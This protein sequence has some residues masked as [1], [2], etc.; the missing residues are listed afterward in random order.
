MVRNIDWK[1]SS[2]QVCERLHELGFEG[3]YDYMHL[4]VFRSGRNNQGFFFVN[5]K[6][7]EVAESFRVQL[8]GKSFGNT[9][10]LCSIEAAKWQGL[11]ELRAGISGKS[12]PKTSP[13][14][15]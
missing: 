2:R 8:Q 10:R 1:L 5:F 6:A 14:F 11:D 7:S 12:K 15:L 13:L 9:A 3:T 4:P